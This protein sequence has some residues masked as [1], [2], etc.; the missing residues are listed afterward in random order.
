LTSLL[1][2]HKIPI[3]R[4]VWALE[5]ESSKKSKH[6]RIHKFFDDQEDRPGRYFAWPRELFIELTLSP[7]QVQKVREWQKQGHSFFPMWNVN[8]KQ[9]IFVDQEAFEEWTLKKEKR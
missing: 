7:K 4:G 6:V 5:P 2:C 8:C 3:P 1:F 9:V